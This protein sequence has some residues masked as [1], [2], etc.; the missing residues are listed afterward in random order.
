MSGKARRKSAGAVEAA[1]RE[2]AKWRAI[3]GERADAKPREMD[4]WEVLSLVCKLFCAGML[5]TQIGKRVSRIRLGPKMTREEP[6]RLLA[7]AA[8]L[9]RLRY[10]APSEHVLQETLRDKRSWLEE[11]VVVSTG[12]FAPMADHGAGMLLRILQKRAR[13]GAEEVHVGLAGGHAVRKVCEAFARK[14]RENPPDLP[15][16]LVFHAMSAGF[17]AG[18]PITAPM[19]YAAYF[20]DKATMPVETS[21]VGVYAPTLVRRAEV[22]HMKSLEGI[23]E[24][25]ERASQLQVILTSASL[26]SDEH[27]LLRRHLASKAPET[28]KAL[29]DSGCI[30]DLMWRSMG[31]D[32]PMAIPGEEMR[33]L[34]IMEL[35]ALPAFIKNGNQVLLVLGPCGECHTPKTEMLKTLLNLKEHLITH[36]VTDSFAAREAVKS[37]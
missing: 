30:G 28:M 18:D 16:R 4:E 7:R 3:L 5:P 6:Y 19:T 8:K 14:L 13:A 29:L 36:L 24:S 11:V 25:F 33:A 23:A 32:G 10:E 12:V 37:L 15:K 20:V 2:E 35:N 34:T 22:D 31:K 1:K 26:W 21:F 17:D 9:N 27:S